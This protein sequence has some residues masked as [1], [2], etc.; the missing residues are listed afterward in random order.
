MRS[1]HSSQPTLSVCLG[2]IVSL[3]KIQSSS[4]RGKNNGCYEKH[5]SRKAWQVLQQEYETKRGRRSGKTRIAIQIMQN[6]KTSDSKR[7]FFS[8][9]SRRKERKRPGLQE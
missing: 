2:Y 9:S 4:R 3:L 6:D 8:P 1:F 5:N 7:H